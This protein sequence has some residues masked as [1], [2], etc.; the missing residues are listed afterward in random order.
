MK[1]SII[2]LKVLISFFAF[3]VFVSTPKPENAPA[4]TSEDTIFLGW[5]R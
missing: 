1:R 3:P 4:P 5:S 2:F